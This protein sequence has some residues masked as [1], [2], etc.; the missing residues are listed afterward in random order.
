MAFSCIL[1]LLAFS[2]SQRV[3]VV[4]PEIIDPLPQFAAR[5]LA[6]PATSDTIRLKYLV[7]P[8]RFAT[9]DSTFSVEAISRTFEGEGQPIS[10]RQFYKEQ[11]RGKV[12]MSFQYEPWLLSSVVRDSLGEGASGKSKYFIDVVEE[13]DS[14]C[15]SRGFQLSDFDNDGDGLV[16]GLI[17]VLAGGEY[18]KTRDPRDPAT[19]MMSY[20]VL[21]SLT[22]GTKIQQCFQTAEIAY[23]RPVQV[24]G[25]THE[26]GHML[27]VA[28]LYD[29][30]DS[31]N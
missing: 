27:G 16:D 19:K 1:P 4:V 12:E 5:A 24:G 9:R 26:L 18:Q 28:E 21:V 15:R 20:P 10:V 11:S 23:G 29:L 31:V 25:V 13:I 14:R 8:V 2:L 6:L 7:V 30:P 17:V 22:S 3:P